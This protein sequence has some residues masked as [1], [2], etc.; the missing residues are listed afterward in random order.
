MVSTFI[1]ETELLRVAAELPAAPRLAVELGQAIRNPRVNSK[2]ITALLR[3][4]PALVARLIRIANGVVYGRAEPAGSL[5][6]AL[7]CIGFQEMHRLVGAVAAA[8]LADQQL[9]FYGV[10]GETLRANSLFVAVIMEEL[11]E[12]TGEEPRSA[13]TVGLLRSIGKMALDRS[14]RGSEAIPPFPT[15]G[16]KD[17]DAWEKKIWGL[18]NCQAAE[19]ILK[20]WRLPHETVIAVQHHYRPAGRH[21]PIIHLLSLAAGAAEDRLYGLQ[22]ETG[23]WKTTPENFAKAGINERGFQ[24]A[25]ERAQRT[26]QRLHAASA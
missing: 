15:S 14:A 22:G 26:F 9:K 13:Y 8:Q 17:F 12:A 24:L 1:S 20:H 3:Q 7:A 4:D 5:E 2:E 6:E 21:N 16:E 19:L 11:A 25:C 10:D 23:Y 18:D